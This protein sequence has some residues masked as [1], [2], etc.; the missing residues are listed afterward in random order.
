MTSQDDQIV[1]LAWK[2]GELLAIVLCVKQQGG[3]A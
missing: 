3:E 2:L 1:V